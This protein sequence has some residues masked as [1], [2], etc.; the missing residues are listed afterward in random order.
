MSLIHDTIKIKYIELGYLPDIPYH[1]ISDAE[2]CNAF[3][4]RDADGY[5]VFDPDSQSTLYEND[6]KVSGYFVD[7]YNLSYM[8]NCNHYTLMQ[9]YYVEMVRAMLHYIDDLTSTFETEYV[10]PTW[11]Y[12][13]MVGSVIHS[14]SSDK[15]RHDSLVLFDCDNINDEFTSDFHERVLA[16]SEFWINTVKRDF[17]PI[18]TELASG[19]NYYPDVI[20]EKR[21]N[22]SEVTSLLLPV[23][24]PFVTPHA[25]K[26][27]RL[28]QLDPDTDSLKDSRY[29]YLDDVWYMIKFNANG[30]SRAP[31][32]QIKY[33][34]I[35]TYI[36]STVPTKKNAVFSSWNT[37]ANGSGTTYRP[38]DKYTGN[39]NAILY[40]QWS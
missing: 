36:S 14:G 33:Q 7:V 2:M 32:S 12:Q 4:H 35:D 9:Q 38:G 27:A 24:S 20:K 19:M 18:S 34:G 22:G 15:D 31:R 10:L 6:I 17:I 3:L 8:K 13:Y 29:K 37:K 5:S 21:D 1:L 26:Y 16:G 39:S 25:I 23:P 28:L 40:A 30:G 11:M